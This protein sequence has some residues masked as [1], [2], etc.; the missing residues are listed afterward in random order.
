MVTPA[1]RH[2]LLA[3]PTPLLRV[4]TALLKLEALRPGA[5][6]DDR[7]L[8][9]WDALPGGE[10]PAGA[11]AVFAGSAGA[12]LAA[13][14]WARARGV[15]LTAIVHGALLHEAR[16]TLGIWRVAWEAAP[17][18]E[19]ALALAARRADEGARL[20]PPLDGPEAAGIFERTLGVELLRDLEEAQ[21]S[22]ALVIAPAGAAAALAGAVRALRPRFPGVQPLLLT[23]R[24]SGDELPELPA[25]ASAPPIDIAGVR[26][27]TVTRAEAAQA[28]AELARELGL[29]AGH[30]GALAAQLARRSAVRAG[31][32]AVALVGSAGEREFSLDAAE[33][34]APVTP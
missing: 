12:A 31:S 27:Q 26:R 19:A 22:P 34:A 30:A 6:F 10:V 18:R 11:D 9:L 29:L 16:E 7:A 20:L 3:R 32:C 28:R 2:P 23:P 21:L 5:G 24:A 17:S 14:S 8:P 15:K 4:G 1:T 33:A 25:A 13:A